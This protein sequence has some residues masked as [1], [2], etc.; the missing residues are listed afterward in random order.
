MKQE[1]RTP[2]SVSVLYNVSGG[3]ISDCTNGGVSSKNDYMILVPEGAEAPT[4]SRW[5]V[6]KVVRR[7]FGSGDY[8]HA[9]PVTPVG[10]GQIGWMFG[11]NFVYTSDSRYRQWVCEYPIAIH[12]RCESYESYDRLSV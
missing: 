6:L 2:L 10:K 4:D 3:V 9:E 5:P 11:G 8:L 7:T 12:D 1:K